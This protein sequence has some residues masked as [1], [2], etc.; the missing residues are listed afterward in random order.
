MATVGK[1]AKGSCCNIIPDQRVICLE[2]L[3]KISL[4]GR[5]PDRDSNQPYYEYKPEPHRLTQVSLQ[6]DSA[7]GII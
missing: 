2:E 1:D 7:L 3:E 6:K 4:Y 5:C